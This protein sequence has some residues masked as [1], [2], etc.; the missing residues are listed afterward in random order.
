MSCRR[1][2]KGASHVGG[3]P[4]SFR[5]HAA[6]STNPSL[7]DSLTLSFH[8]PLSYCRYW[9]ERMQRLRE[10]VFRCG[11]MSARTDK[12]RPIWEEIK[13]AALDGAIYDLA[14]LLF[15]WLWG[16]AVI[17]AVVGFLG[18]YLHR[19]K[20]VRETLAVSV[21]VFIIVLICFPA[22]S[23]KTPVPPAPQLIAGSRSVMIGNISKDES[24]KPT[25]AVLVIRIIN[26]GFYSEYCAMVSVEGG[27][28][29]GDI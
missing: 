29:W 8:V 28:R 27:H 20:S 9:R 21:G 4:A 7:H 6:V 19:F 11:L 12:R 1:I 22:V 5:N 18:K 16:P 2:V 15:D 17:A 23:T 10:T 13:H 14:K 25:T 26:W 24:G 3:A